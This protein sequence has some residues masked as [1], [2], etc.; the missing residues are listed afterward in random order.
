MPAAPLVAVVD[1]SEQVVEL[2]AELLHDAGFRTATLFAAEDKGPLEGV[3]FLSAHKPAACVYS[4]SLP[5]KASWATLQ[6][7]RRHMP[8]CPF[9]VTTT[10][11]RALHGWSGPGETLE[12]VGKPFAVEDLLAAVHRVVTA[13]PSSAAPEA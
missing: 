5:Y 8:D 2:I 13:T 1:S 6:A 10:N 9:I 11:V 3:D 7:L 4:S 12:V